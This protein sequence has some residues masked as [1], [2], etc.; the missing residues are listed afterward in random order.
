MV[1][2]DVDW[3]ATNVDWDEPGV[4]WDVVDVRTRNRSLQTKEV[5]TR[6]ASELLLGT[7]SRL[8]ICIR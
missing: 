1:C 7:E 6:D 5:Q 2:I 8:C 4:T 3:D